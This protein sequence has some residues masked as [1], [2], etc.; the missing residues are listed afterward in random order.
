MEHIQNSQQDH[1]LG[2]IA[3]E[4]MTYKGTKQ[5]LRQNTDYKIVS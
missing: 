1:V 3:M 5:F 2:T 4:S